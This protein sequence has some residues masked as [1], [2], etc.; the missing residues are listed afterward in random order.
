MNPELSKL[1]AAVDAGLSR[2]TAITERMEARESAIDQT[3]RE[4]ERL[5]NRP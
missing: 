2:L 3:I 4:I 1:L 5:V